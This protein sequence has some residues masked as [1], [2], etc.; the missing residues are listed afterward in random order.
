MQLLPRSDSLGDL[1]HRHLRLLPQQCSDPGGVA[2]LLEHALHPLGPQPIEVG[3]ADLAAPKDEHISTP[4]AHLEHDRR[5]LPKERLPLQS[6]AHRLIDQ[7]VDIRLLKNLDVQPRGDR[8]A[9]E[10]LIAIGRLAHRAGCHHLQMRP[11]GESILLQCLQKDLQAIDTCLDR[12]AGDI[13]PG[14]AL[15]PERDPLLQRVNQP[16][17]LASPPFG[18]RHADGGGPNFDH[19]SQGDGLMVV[20]HMGFPIA[21]GCRLHPVLDYTITTSLGR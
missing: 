4:A 20:S 9:V 17:R 2:M 18:H 15:T 19:R 1:L 11:R 12:G 14:H 7:P 8:D 5:L 10:K 21:A 6:R 16:W 3:G 13:P